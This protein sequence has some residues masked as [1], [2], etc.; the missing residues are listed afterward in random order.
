MTDSAKDAFKLY[1]QKNYSGALAVLL[2]LPSEEADKN[3]DIA[4]LTGLCLARMGRD[5]D[6]I[7]C[8][9][10]V[11]TTEDADFARIYQCRLALAVL[12]V[13]TGR[14]H[15]AEFE[16]KK[17]A[18]LGYESVQVFSALGFVLYEAG[19][20]DKSLEWYE[21]ALAMDK[22]NATALNGMGYVLANAGGDLRRALVLCKQAFADDPDNP[23][24]LDSL[25]WVYHK[26]G[27]DKEARTYIKR[28]YEMLPDNETVLEH[29][30]AISE[31]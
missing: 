15:L 6:A 29:F 16:L 2:S 9:E 4:Y 30:K 3:P 24:Y 12:Y 1:E 18:E 21:K 22:K 5:E 14:T 20:A 10:Q 23:A 8:L 28:A 11:V 27:L 26:L 17:I 13:R 31:P 25:A 19:D 7:G